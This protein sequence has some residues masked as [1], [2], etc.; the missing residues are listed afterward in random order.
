MSRELK[1]WKG[2]DC[3]KPRFAQEDYSAQITN[4]GEIGTGFCSSDIRVWALFDH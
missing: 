1:G 3:I 4:F 2:W